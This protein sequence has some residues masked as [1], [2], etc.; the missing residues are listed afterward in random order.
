MEYYAAL[1]KERGHSPCTNAEKSLG[2]TVKDK[3]LVTEQV[4]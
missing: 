4:I 2:H 1:T 3:K